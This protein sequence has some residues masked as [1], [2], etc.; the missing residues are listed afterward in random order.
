MQEGGEWLQA[1]AKLSGNWHAVMQDAI[2][3]QYQIHDVSHQRFIRDKVE[4][5]GR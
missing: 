5:R 2:T 4:L 3:A 1:E